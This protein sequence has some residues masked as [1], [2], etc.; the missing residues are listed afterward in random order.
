MQPFNT[1]GESDAQ[2]LREMTPDELLKEQKSKA[3]KLP[4]HQDY[5]V[6][7]WRQESFPALKVKFCHSLEASLVC[8]ESNFKRMLWMETFLWSL[9]ISWAFPTEHAQEQ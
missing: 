7:V 5:W 9:A 6:T 4:K 2:P 1:V 8:N 3:K